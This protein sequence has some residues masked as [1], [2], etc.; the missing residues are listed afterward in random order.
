MLSVVSQFLSS[1]RTSEA[2]STVGLEGGALR[3][4][5]DAMVIDVGVEGQACQEIFGGVFFKYIL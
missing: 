5:K 1:W 3:Y 4:G 2:L